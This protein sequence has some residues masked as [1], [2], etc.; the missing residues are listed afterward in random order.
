MSPIDWL[1]VVLTA[2]AAVAAVALLLHL[3][4][5]Q[6][7][8]R[9][10]HEAARQAVALRAARGEDIAR[11]LT[12]S[13]ERYF[14]MHAGGVPKGPADLTTLRAM[15]ADGRL[16]VDAFAAPCGTEGWRPVGELLDELRRAGPAAA[17]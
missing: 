12:A 1:T 9:V 14:Y 11:P 16:E 6:R 13:S 15:V 17:A 8:Q 5:D 10:A 7:L 3:W 2:L 4:V